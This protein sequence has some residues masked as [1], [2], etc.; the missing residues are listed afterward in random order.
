MN[1]LYFLTHHFAPVLAYK[2]ATDDA[3]Y[4]SKE[5]QA[6]TG[7]LVIKRKTIRIS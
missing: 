5:E 1:L 4:F 6:S 7:T 2:T 3:Q